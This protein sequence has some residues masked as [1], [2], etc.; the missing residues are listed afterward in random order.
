MLA[1][2]TVF[3]SNNVCIAVFFPCLVFYAVSDCWLVFCL[4]SRK[5]LT[6]KSDHNFIVSHISEPLQ[7]NSCHFCSEAFCLT[8]VNSF[9]PWYRF[10]RFSALGL[11]ES[12]A[13]GKKSRSN[14]GSR[15]LPFACT[16][17]FLCSKH[18]GESSQ[19]F[20]YPLLDAQDV[21]FHEVL[22][23]WSSQLRLH[24]LFLVS[25]LHAKRSLVEAHSDWRTVSPRLRGALC[26]ILHG[27]SSAQ[28][29]RQPHVEGGYKGSANNVNGNN[30][31]VVDDVLREQRHLGRDG[32][33]LKKPHTM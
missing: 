6:F 4:L 30:Q 19:F 12:K 31:I 10:S 17:S 13:W 18:E 25:G 9:P 11:H 15:S 29:H 20:W 21:F 28:R 26:R 14:W 3:W 22:K 7:K 24:L 1:T 2:G 5:D 32:S 8:T 23:G 33:L 16:R 27:D